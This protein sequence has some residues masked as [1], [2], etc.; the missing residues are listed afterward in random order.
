MIE[1]TFVLLGT[2]AVWFNSIYTTTKGWTIAKYIINI[3]QKKCH[4]MSEE[5]NKKISQQEKVCWQFCF[6][7]VH[8]LIPNFF[9]LCKYEKCKR[10]TLIQKRAFLFFFLLFIVIL[11]SRDYIFIYIIRTI[12][13]I[14]IFKVWLKKSYYSK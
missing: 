3:K 5:W 7:L 4:T 11:S 13:T 6:F 1:H 10:N 8:I 2:R 12:S 9:Y 14:V